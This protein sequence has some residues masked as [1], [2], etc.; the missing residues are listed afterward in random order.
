MTPEEALLALK[1]VATL[2]TALFGL[3]LYA[4]IRLTVYVWR[5][6]LDRVFVSTSVKRYVAYDGKQSGTSVVCVDCT[7]RH[8]PTLTHHKDSTTPKHLRGDTST[9]TVF[10]ALHAGWRPLKVAD[11]VTCNH[12][13]IDG[14]ISVWAL[15]DPLKALEH[16]DVLREAARIGDFR[17]LRV[18]RG[19]DDTRDG[20]SS[21]DANPNRPYGMWSETAAALKL[22]AWINS[23]E[24]TLFT[25]PFEGVEEDESVKKFEHFLPLMT[26]ALDAVEPPEG[27]S[28]ATDEALAAKCGIHDGDEETRRVLEGVERLYG[29]VS[30]L[31]EWDGPCERCDTLGVC[32]VRYDEPVHYY[33]LFSLAVDSDVVVGVYNGNRYEVESRYVGFVDYQSRPSWPRLNLSALA[34]KLNAMDGAVTRAGSDLRW[35]VAGLTDSGPLLR[36]NDQ[37][38]RL[39]R[40]ERYGH[41]D[42]RPI[43][44]SELSPD[45]FV[46]TCRGFFEHAA[47][48]ARVHLNAKTNAEVPKRGWTWKETHELNSAVDYDAFV[49]GS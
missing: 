32:V 46:A 48:G 6:L 5:P 37:K 26:T 35:D 23:R 4:F 34:K 14:L 3:L 38:R 44:A 43:Y 20:S 2:R 47:D 29:N 39:T 33:A 19:G 30:G 8:L 27:S 7:H 42:E 28:T 12:F 10:N 16:E 49:N 45:R 18:T 13:D 15:I 40:A 24:R 21:D 11:A 36:L 25:R 31:S 1:T 9:D 17:E 22:C 41:P